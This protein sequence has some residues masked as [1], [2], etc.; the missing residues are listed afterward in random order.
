VVE[1]LGDLA[2]WRWQYDVRDLPLKTMTN[3]RLIA[4]IR[5]GSAEPLDAPNYPRTCPASN[6]ALRRARKITTT[7]GRLRRQEKQLI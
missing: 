3:Q 6:H 1:S 2:A 5:G 4:V 7:S